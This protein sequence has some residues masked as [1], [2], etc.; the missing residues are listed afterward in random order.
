MQKIK[1]MLNIVLPKSQSAFLWGPRK[2]GK[3]TY[4]RDAFSE[5]LYYDFL[6]TDMA[7]E[8]IKRPS[9]LREQLLAKDAY[10]LKHPIILDEVQ[11]VPQILD[12]V[13]WLIENK[14]LNFILCGSSARKLKRGKANLLGGRAW[15]YEM[16]PLV[17]EEL[18]DINLLRV[19]NRGMIPDH[20]L[21]DDYEKS[22]RGY[23]QDYL[24]EEV[25][26]EG[27]TRNIPAFA[28][29]FDTVGYTHGELTNFS[30]I[31]RDCG[32]DAK[33]IREYYQILEDTLLGRMVEPFKKRQSR[34]IIIK[35]PKFYLFDVGVA[36]AIVKRHLS[37]ERG[38]AFGRAFEHFIF[39]EI[40]AHASYSELNYAIQYWRTKSRLEVDFILGGGEVSIEVKGQSHVE[41]RDLRPLAAFMDEYRPN[42]ALVVCNEREERVVGKIKILPWGRFLEELWGGRI[43]S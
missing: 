1:R 40:V 4:L 13:H 20:Y 14:K 7:L 10:F 42:K 34:Q 26:A 16:F 22:L 5:S 11:K 32:V 15:R 2:I 33:T 38:E 21:R 28:R 19:L 6:K 24:K 12:E 17:T 8:F 41:N 25:F 9:L 37:E 43:I 36:G 23:V 35:T 3:S 39:M 30:N 31:A 27:L 29:F 18:K